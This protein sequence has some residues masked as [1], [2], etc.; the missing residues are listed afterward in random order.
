LCDLG[1]KQAPANNF[2]L[3]VTNAPLCGRVPKEGN[4]TWAPGTLAFDSAG[5]EISNMTDYCD[6]IRAHNPG[7]QKVIVLAGL[8][9]VG[10]SQNVNT[11]C[12]NVQQEHPDFDVV[13]TIYTDFSQATAVPQ[14]NAALL[15]HP[16]TTIVASIYS[17]LTKGTVQVLKQ[18]NKKNVKVYDVGGD[19]SV[20]P[21]I[22]SGDVQMTIPY[23][24]VTM[25]A[26]AIQAIYDARVGRTPL[27]HFYN[28]SGHPKP[29]MQGNEPLLAITKENLDAYKRSGLS[30]Y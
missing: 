22:E 10:E 11:A 19:A 8:P 23:W 18:Q 13:D 30:E 1:T 16:D 25:G 21:F 12:H 20:L 3:V 14:M 15:R 5:Q 2:M 9:T 17:E 28:Q 26:T 27:T 6:Y 29:V 24:P 7:K 4:D